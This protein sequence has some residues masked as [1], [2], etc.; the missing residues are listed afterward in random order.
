MSLTK[1]MMD[2]YQSK[3]LSNSKVEWLIEYGKTHQSVYFKGAIGDRYT[4]YVATK[5]NK[6]TVDFHQIYNSYDYGTDEGTHIATIKNYVLKFISETGGWSWKNGCG[7]LVKQLMKQGVCCN[8]YP[9]KIRWCRSA[10][11]MRVSGNVDKGGYI[12]F[13]P[14]IGMKI[15]LKT[16]VLVNK[17]NRAALKEYKTAKAT[18]TRM[19]KANALSNKN[20]REA[21]ER[22]KN[23]GG[24]TLIARGGWSNGRW[25]EAVPGAVSTRADGTIDWDMIPMDDIFKHRNATLRSNILEHYGINTVLETLSHNVVD[26]DFIDGRE[27]K[28]LDVEIPDNSTGDRINDRCLYLQMVNPSTGE[29]HFEGIAN[30][31]QWNAPKE[32]T[33]KEAL[34]WRDGDREILR[35]GDFLKDDTN[36]VV[37]IKPTTLT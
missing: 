24:N 20:N 31:G 21:I 22:Y 26:I 15:N 12:E 13:S 18:D 10:Y 36:K 32:A 23:A 11:F 9:W 35:A 6:S 28:L 29:N 37:Y 17:P 30:V 3:H 8:K 4:I 7:H 27:Y 16:G 34:S 19:R 14:W 1:N 25:Q 2:D 5:R 33:V